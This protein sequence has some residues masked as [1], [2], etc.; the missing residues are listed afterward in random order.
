MPE[1]NAKKIYCLVSHTHWDR[2]WY[3]PF[4][5][6]RVRLVN[7]VDNLLELLEHDKDFIFHLDAQAAVLD[8]YLEIKPQNRERLVVLIKERRLMAG[9]WYIQNDFF[10][11]SGEATVRNLLLGT[12]RMKDFGTSDDVAYMPDQFGLISQLPQILKGFGVES[13]VFS[14]GLAGLPGEEGEIPGK[15][16]FVWKSPDGTGITAIFMSAFYNNAQRLSADPEKALKFI[17][18]A[19]SKI[20]ERSGTPFILLMNGVDHLEAQENLGEIIRK[21]RPL[22]G[23]DE[24]IRQVRLSDYVKNAA[25]SMSNPSEKWV[26]E[27]R[28]GFVLNGTLCSRTYIKILN[29][30]AQELLEKILE[31]LS[32]IALMAGFPAKE[33][34][35]EFLDYLWKT[36]ILNHPHD[37][38]CGC[39]RDEVHRHMEDRYERIFETA[40]ILLN[41]QLR[42]LSGH[43]TGSSAGA[44]TLTVFNTLPFARSNVVDAVLEFPS[45]KKVGAFRILS[46]DKKG[47]EVEVLAKYRSEK[48][49]RSPINLPGKIDVDCYKIRFH[50][51]ELPAMGFRQY[52][53]EPLT[54]K[55][56]ILKSAKDVTGELENEFLKVDISANGKID[57]LDKT[58]GKRFKDIL[59]IEEVE[60]FGESY[61]HK[62]ASCGKAIRSS[63]FAY[64]ISSRH[65]D[66]FTDE[67]SISFNM[68]VPAFYEREKKCRS[69]RLKNCP[70][71]LTLR[72]TKGKGRL[73]ILFKMDNR[74]EDHLVRAV[75]NTGIAT[76]T[77]DASAPFDIVTRKIRA[78][79]P[80]DPRNLAMEPMSDFVSVGNGKDAVA[81]LS[82]GLQC[83]EHLD[84]KGKIGLPLLR[85]NSY[86]FISASGVLPLDP[87]WIAPG[88]QCK[89][90]IEAE[91][92]IM[93]C[94]NEKSVTNAVLDYRTAL[95]SCWDSSDPK[96][97]SGG[98]PCV[99]DSELSEIFYR[100]DPYKHIGLENEKSLFALNGNGI[101]FSTCKLSENGKSLIFRFFNSLE[102][103]N[104]ASVK[105]GFSAAK[106][107]EATLA[108]KRLGEVKVVKNKVAL[109]IKPKEIKTLEIVL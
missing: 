81:V 41:K 71:R 55:I 66:P 74:V 99:Q 64:K 103:K 65:K 80:D 35:K 31:P 51:E 100:E 23:K 84:K 18:S 8:D 45:E 52:T 88:N 94:A 4:E 20:E 40:S 93:P 5:Q 95:L 7:L 57:I 33:Y 1:K 96:E 44:Y 58:S 87:A 89:G 82:K 49:L 70:A 73:D 97:F 10:L 6:F 77:V 75:I 78:R 85:G 39:S 21:L 108:E 76:E 50:A 48:P 32:S 47:A 102:S 34:G 107:Y 30:K 60:D 27:M 61:C 38:I 12:R 17:R 72:L 104:T 24:D 43:V 101:V 28:R 29:N 25:K 56:A 53:V 86:V 106:V 98:R 46:P 14:R 83:Y 109:K 105:L 42:L 68:R 63:S 79:N 92:A 36:L 54:G 9:P 59:R 3:E 69:K 67:C 16:E 13:A 37:S 15:N 90:P 22:L 62:A 26:G 91:F 11:T 2:E 19:V